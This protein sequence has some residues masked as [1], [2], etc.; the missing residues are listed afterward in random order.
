ML[1]FGRRYRPRLALTTLVLFSILAVSMAL[2]STPGKAT[3]K[4]SDCKEN[5]I[6]LL[7]KEKAEY[8]FN[9]CEQEVYS[10]QDGKSL[11]RIRVVSGEVTERWE[12]E[13]GYLAVC[14]ILIGWFDNSNNVV[15][16]VDSPT[17]A[18]HDPAVYT[19][20]CGDI[21][22][23]SEFDT[24]VDSTLVFENEQYWWRIDYENTI[25]YDVDKSELEKQKPLCVI[26]GTSM[27]GKTEILSS[28]FAEYSS[29]SECEPEE[30][31]A[32]KATAALRNK[33]VSHC[34]DLTAEQK[35]FDYQCV[36]NFIAQTGD[37][38]LCGTTANY[39]SRID[40]ERIPKIREL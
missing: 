1:I 2:G 18:N 33:S 19:L 37:T 23:L 34:E 31:S 35:T 32:C 8:S 21:N 25:V 16:F 30:T 27:I 12:H 24:K 39:G 17:V 6:K 10:T 20:G 26:N 29:L 15:E 36:R 9:R 3:E 5:A 40:C 14:N 4:Y 22:S 38:E 7:E 11:T 28:V 13:C